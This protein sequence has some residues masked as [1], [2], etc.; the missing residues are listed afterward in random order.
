MIISKHCNEREPFTRL[1]DVKGYTDPSALPTSPPIGKIL[2]E[3]EVW[4]SGI[5][6]SLWSWIEKGIRST[7]RRISIPG[8]CVASLDHRIL[9]IP[10]AAFPLGFMLQT[11]VCCDIQTRKPQINNLPTNQDHKSALKTMTLT[12]E[13]SFSQSQYANG[14]CTI[15]R[16]CFVKLNHESDI[17]K[18]WDWKDQLVFRKYLVHHPLL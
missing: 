1:F 11:L 5:F 16:L 7:V 4:N 2:T 13:S 10:Y 18:T 12:S 9:P 8:T 3:P 15:T 17:L 6:I 14:Q